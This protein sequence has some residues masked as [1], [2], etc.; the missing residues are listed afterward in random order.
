MARTEAEWSKRPRLNPRDYVSTLVYTDPDIFAQEREKIHRAVWKF[1]CHESELPNANDFRT[2]DH[3]GTQ[4]VVARGADG[5]I[6]AFV[7]SCSH[8]GALVVRAAAGNAAHWTCLF[9]HW[10]Y[11]TSGACVAIP[12]DQAYEESGVCKAGRGLRAVRTAVKLGMVFVNLD[13]TA[14]AFDDYV[15]DAFEQLAPVMGAE[16]LEVIQLYRNVVNANWKL[17]QEVQME[18]Y[19]ENLHFVNRQ[20]AMGAP[21]YFARKWKIYPNAHG[22]LEPMQQ[23]YE[24]IKGW[25]RRDE[26]TLPG[27]KPGEFRIVDLFPD[28]TII[29]RT[30]VM[31]IDTMVA[32]A[33]DKTLLVTRGLGIKGEA[34]EDRLLRTKHHNQYWGPFGRNYA[35]DVIAPEAVQAAIQE[36]GT[37]YGV[38]ARHEDERGQDDV[39]VRSFYAEWSRRLGISA[40]DPKAGT[41]RAAE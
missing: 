39:L 10:M 21:G 30:T 8:R 3:A 41:V 12:R 15:G 14:P 32:L 22:T 18:L 4:L 7:N 40:S 19:H 13:D 35:E 29:V 33:P 16:P 28:T 24:V 26:R 17:L 23:K 5:A 36:G 38:F 27:L 11:D 1:A 6:R 31:R 9:H 25:E 2:L 20:V 37:P 34:P